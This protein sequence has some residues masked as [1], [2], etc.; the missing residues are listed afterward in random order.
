MQPA[1]P[2]LAARLCSTWTV[3][4]QAQALGALARGLTGGRRRLSARRTLAARATR[5][6]DEG[7]AAMRAL[8]M[9]DGVLAGYGLFDDDG[10]MRASGPPDA[11]GAPG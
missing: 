5:I 11:T 10:A 3:T 4:L 7:A 6:A 2:A 1:D 8:L 9:V